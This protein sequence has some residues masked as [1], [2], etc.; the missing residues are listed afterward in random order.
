MS[1]STVLTIA[2][3]WDGN[4]LPEAEQATI[5]VSAEANGLMLQVDAPFWGDPR[6][7]SPPGPTPGLWEHE[8]VELFLAAPASADPVIAYTE[9]E[10]GPHG[11]HLV[12]R[13][14]GVR[15]VVEQGLPLTFTA[16]ISPPSADGSGPRWRGEALLPASYL[17]ARD[18]ATLVANA[19]AIHGRGA[20]RRYL[21]TYPVPGASP[22]FHQPHRFHN[23]F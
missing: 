10:L 18:P 3:T 15:N 7:N 16:A 9:V 12:L 14:R 17:A 22:D 6:P 21:A 20:S 11:H 4:P 23:L 19:F 5:R 8:V 1:L 2:G 13:L